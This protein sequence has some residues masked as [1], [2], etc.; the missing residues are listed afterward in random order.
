MIDQAYADLKA[1]Y[2][3]SRNDYFGLLYLEKQL[4][5]PRERALN[6]V[7]FGGNDY[8]V[9]GFHFD[10]ERRNFYIFQFKYSD[11]YTG[12]KFSMERL[13]E[14]GIERVFRESNADATKNQFLL[15]LR[16][17][18]IENRFLIHQVCFHF[19]F[20]G[21]PA[22]AE[23]S[24]VLDKLR[25][26]LENKKYLIDEF[27]QGR[28]VTMVVQYRSAAGT[29]GPVT[30]ERRTW[31]YR[32]PMESVISCSGPNQEHM[33]V[34]LVPLVEF[35]RMYRDMGR[36]FFERNVRDWL[37]P[38]KSVTRAILGAL[39]QIVLEGT[40]PPSVFAFDHNGVTLAAEQVE[41][42]DGWCTLS[43]P[44]LLNGAQTVKTLDEFLQTNQDDPR[45]QERQ[46]A[47]AKI[48]VLSKI[49]TRAHDE[50]I[51]RVTINNNRQNPI[52]PWNLRANDRIQLEL[53][54]KFRDDLSIY[55]ERQERAFASLT[56]EEMEAEGIIEGKAI[57][58]VKLAQTFLVSDGNISLLSDMRRVFEE[59]KI[60]NEVF[61]P[62]RLKADSRQIV[63]CYKIQFRLRRLRDEIR[64]KGE[65]KYW[66]VDR[67]RDLLWALLCQGVLNDPKGAELVESHGKN[68]TVTAE[69]TEYLGR[70]ASTRCRPLLA[71]LI[72]Q[73][74]YAA[75][76]AEGSSGFLRSNAAFSRCMKVAGE[77]WGWVHKRLA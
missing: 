11:S 30:D 38:E 49:I 10:P 31:T 60:Y 42:G 57:Q 4:G 51:T 70:I 76:L 39:R 12:F 21:H 64:E 69:Y 59:D 71:D 66:F 3:G 17:T 53:H 55:Y 45:L 36:R 37:G 34:G 72:K 1:T 62:A 24:Q 77:R 41:M 23:R 43:S 48:S 46:E 54:D 14:H 15:Q 16:S 40:E 50:F 67:A 26:D 22:D 5:V 18:L 32:V 28:Q 25:E 75:K 9:D 56:P 35:H 29:V 61:S 33:Y 52:Q 27:F 20:L 44:R 73:P 2:G 47:L 74:E 8:G 63:L 6:Q 68:L 13:I 65:Q 7:A 58:L 19:V